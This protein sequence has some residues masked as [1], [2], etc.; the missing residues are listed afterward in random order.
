MTLQTR[1]LLMVTLLLA[2]A[3]LATAAVLTWTARQSL[4][5]QV[6]ADGI[7]IARLLARGVEFADQA[8]YD[9][10]E[11][12]SGENVNAIWIV[13]TN[14]VTLAH[15]AAPGLDVQENLGAKDAA[16][17]VTTLNR[18]RS[19]GW[20]HGSMLKAAA[21]IVDA[22]DQVIGATLVYLSIESVQTTM[23]REL[24]LA[25]VVAVL[26]LVLGLSAF[27]VLA[28]RVAGP[29]VRLTEAAAQVEAETFDPEELT[30]VAT[31][32]DELGQLA[33]VFQRMAREVQAR[34]RRLKQQVQ[35]LRIEVDQV[36]RARQVA[37]ITDTGYF[38]QLREKAEE[39]RRKR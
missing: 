34:E 39:I 8:T 10:D 25:G 24:L 22:Q 32:A 9:V 2:V 11:L 28:R 26:V 33:R 17:L 37:E 20:Q 23:R 38:E 14:F 7:V 4:L 5:D 12:V 16:H 36:K 35:E 18:G 30:D 1:A 15:G 3:V 21:P 27:I 29:V 19:I 13:D 6:R 31:R